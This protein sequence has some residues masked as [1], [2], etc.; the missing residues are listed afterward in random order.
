MHLKFRNV[1]DAFETLMRR[2][3]TGAIPTVKRDSRNGPVRV[4]P[5]PL[6]I[7][8]ERPYERVLLNPARDCNPFFHLYEAMWML[9]GRNDVESLAFYNP[10]MREFSDDGKTLN[11]AYGY[12][13][14]YYDNS[15]RTYY[16]TVDQLNVLIGHLKECP[17]SRRAVLQ[18]WDVEDDLLKIGEGN[19]TCTASKDHYPGCRVH[20]QSKD[21]CCNLSVKFSLR[22]TCTQLPDYADKT[23][24]IYEDVLDMTVFN[25]SN[26]LLW[27]T[28]GA[29]YVHFSFLQDYVASALGVQIGVYNQISDDAHV[30]E[31]RF[32]PEKWFDKTYIG[33]IFAYKDYRHSNLYVLDRR[34]RFD[35]R[36]NILVDNHPTRLLKGQRQEHEGW[37]DNTFIDNTVEPALV[38][39]FEYK[40]LKET[41]TAIETARTIQ[42]PD[43]QVACV[44]WLKRRVK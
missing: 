27:G 2:I 34:E 23:D 1:N 39:F 32:T 42:E 24:G 11:G 4:I 26:D 12:R 17:N 31:E 40:E 33:D 44:E 29:N 5:E 22:K 25:R 43:W 6:T 20:R 8:Y 13:W 19:C 36:C 38:A 21:V 15:G 37:V 7:T 16:S 14:R 10:R 28:L 3:E 41:E 35:R 18:M 9:A 30:Y